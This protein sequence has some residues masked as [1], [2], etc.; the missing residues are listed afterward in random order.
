MYPD[1]LIFYLF[2]AFIGGVACAAHLSP[3][4]RKVLHHRVPLLTNAAGGPKWWW[5]WIG[6][7]PW[8]ITIGGAITFSAFL[9]ALAAF[10]YY[11]TGVHWFEGSAQSTSGKSDAEYAARGVG[12]VANLVMGLL[13]L[14][15]AKN[16]ILT[17]AFGIAWEQVL[18]MHTWLGGL[19]LGLG[20]VHMF[21]WWAVYSQYH[22]FSDSMDTSQFGYPE[23][24]S[25]A[26]IYGTGHYNQYAGK[27]IMPAEI[28][29]VPMQ[30]PC[31]ASPNR[32]SATPHADNWTIQLVFVSFMIALLAMGGFARYSVRRR[33]FE[34]F[35]YAHHAY[36]ASSSLRLFASSSLLNDA[37][38]QLSTVDCSIADW[39]MS[40]CP[41]L[42]RLPPIHIYIYIYICL[43]LLPL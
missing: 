16:S 14:P 24:Y 37:A 19:F 13:L 18:W 36:V 33:N 2:L 10:T 4:L 38:W 23:I 43:P 22:I 28:F 29:R 32:C 34:L 39:W 42:T 8:S 35:Y 25:P 6:A 21:L 20:L 15:V 26:G 30:Y 1:V 17:S 5:N 27:S 12:Q 31:N 3:T 11:W 41:T 7:P 40:H 9:G